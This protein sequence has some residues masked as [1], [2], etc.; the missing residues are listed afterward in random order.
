MRKYLLA[1]SLLVT[2]STLAA[3][4][5][6]VA[7]PEST[8]RAEAAADVSE[9]GESGQSDTAS[10]GKDPK[11]SEQSSEV[12]N[13]ADQNNSLPSASAEPLQIAEPFTEY[14][15]L[16]EAEDASGIAFS[17][18]DALSGYDEVT[19]F[20]FNDKSMIEAVYTDKDGN[21]MT[22]RKGKGD[23]DGD[24]TTYNFS[25]PEDLTVQISGKDR[26]D[27]EVAMSGKSASALRKALWDY[28]GFHY[29]A[30]S[31]KDSLN[32][33]FLSLAACTFYGTDHDQDITVSAPALKDEGISIESTGKGV[34]IVR[35]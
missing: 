6:H 24:Y 22:I 18:P 9:Q 8:S 28:D 30:Y 12:Q 15:T 2:V 34:R 35:K 29:A 3:G 26:S 5:G 4:C 16:K 19:Y 21:R 32:T 17:V 1:V 25:D 13:G 7:G 23:I 11:E 10:G 33:D 20:A 27:V 31:D 14:R